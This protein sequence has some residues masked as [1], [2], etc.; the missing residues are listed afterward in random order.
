MSL[1]DHE[2]L[3]QHVHLFGMSNQSMSRPISPSGQWGSRH[4]GVP[5]PPMAVRRPVAPPRPATPAW[6]NAHRN[7]PTRPAARPATRPFVT[8]RARPGDHS[9]A[10]AGSTC[11]QATVSD[12]IGGAPV[13]IGGAPV[14]I[15]GAPAAIVVPHIPPDIPANSARREQWRRTVRY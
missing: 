8:S 11:K 13:A 12:P 9:P 2:C 6:L 15:G 1:H 4:C 14:A 7:P 5:H 3:I 10:A